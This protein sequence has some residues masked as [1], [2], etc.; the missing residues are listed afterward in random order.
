MIHFLFT[1]L[2]AK[3]LPFSAD[4]ERDTIGIGYNRDRY[5]TQLARDFIEMSLERYKNGWKDE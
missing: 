3:I 2:T 1:Y 4:N 5:L